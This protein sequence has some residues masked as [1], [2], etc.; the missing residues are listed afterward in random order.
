MSASSSGDDAR[1]TGEAQSLVEPR[2]HVERGADAGEPLVRRFPP[3][4][5]GGEDRFGFLAAW[6]ERFAVAAGV[7]IAEEIVD[8]AHGFPAHAV[9]VG[10]RVAQGDAVVIVELFA[11]DEV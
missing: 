8:A 6:T 4:L 5:E 2:L 3:L 7:A 10:R 11:V 1:Q 9:G